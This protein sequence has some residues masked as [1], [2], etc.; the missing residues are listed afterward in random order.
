MTSR[1][2][3]SSRQ[4]SPVADAFSHDATQAP[5]PARPW[6][7]HT[8]GAAANDLWPHPAAPLLFDTSPRTVTLQRAGGALKADVTL[9]RY[10]GETVVCKD[11]RRWQHTALAPVARY[12]MTREARMLRRLDG[13]AHTPDFN[14]FD[15]HYAFYMSAI[16]GLELGEAHRRG[17]PVR[18]GEIQRVVGELHH[19]HITHNDLRWTNIM[20]A[21][22][23][24]LVLIDMASAFHAAPRRP[25]H[26]IMNRLRRTDM[27]GTLKFKRRLT[28]RSLTP[29]E[30]RLKAA[31]RW[32]SLVRRGWKH[33]ILPHLERR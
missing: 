17:V 26:P 6:R 32:L 20:V 23:G 19:F 5:S 11:Y 31:P 14:G 16:D 9:T 18:Y 22:D 12:L 8:S 33:H 24:R 25:L 29:T 15:G 3:R 27:A 4:T 10:R 7:I 2:S 28:G 21:S 1:F 30:Q 13:W